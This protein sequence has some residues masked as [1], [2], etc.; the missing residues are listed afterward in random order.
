M[1]V[2]KH[3]EPYSMRLSF[4]LLLKDQLLPQMRV[5][6]V[7]KAQKTFSMEIET[8]TEIVDVAAAFSSCWYKNTSSR[9]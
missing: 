2:Q 3:Q 6:A 4:R 9:G 7:S 1:A 5:F 8:Q